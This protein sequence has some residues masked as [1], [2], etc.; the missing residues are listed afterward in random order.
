M[1]LKK[2]Q[3]K[4]G[5]CHAIAVVNG[6]CALALALLASGVKPSTEV[7]LPSLTFVATANAIIQANAIPHFVESERVSYGIC[8]ASLRRY[9]EQHCKLRNGKCINMSSGNVVSAIMPVHIFGCI[10]DMTALGELAKDFHLSIIEDSTEALGSKHMGI[11]AGNFGESGTLSFNGN[12][13]ITTGGGGAVLTNNDAIAKKIRH[14]ASQA[15]RPTRTDITMTNMR[16]IS[17]C[18]RSMPHLVV[19]NSTNSTAF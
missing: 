2:L 14:L 16:L 3:I 9:L 7:L 11:H 10:G 8:C 4:T 18:Q 13:I 6:T 1:N 12:K 19:H 17:E 15:K 5:A